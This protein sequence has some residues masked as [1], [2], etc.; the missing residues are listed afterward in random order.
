MSYRIPLFA[1]NM[2]R[3][4]EEAVVR[5]LRS[6]WISMGPECEALEAEFAAATGTRYGVAV[7]N[8]T[9]ALHMALLAKGCGVGDEVIVPSLT[10]AATA[11]AVRYTG[12]EPVFADIVSDDE[13]LV[14]RQTIE[15]VVSPR[16]KGIIVMHYA[17]FPVAFDEIEAFAKANGLFLVEDACHAPLSE[18]KGR[19][20]GSLGDVGC[21]SFFSNKNISSGEG[22]MLT[23]DD[24]AIAKEFGL[25]RSHGM[26]VSSYRRSEGHATSYNIEEVGYNYRLDDIRASIARVQ[27]EKLPADLERRARVRDWYLSALGDVE[28][29]T[30]PFR[31]R[32]AF[33]SNYIMPVALR[34]GG[35]RQRDL[36]REAMH[37][38]GVQTSNHYPPV[39]RFSTYGRDDRELPRTASFSDREITLPMYGSLT[40]AQVGEVVEALAAAITETQP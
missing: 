6:R 38:R 28:A 37:R 18:Y 30:V 13:P 5:T 7:A 34:K 10:F 19:K 1:L 15:R 9:V 21:F 2:D 25:L 33:S 31:D 12:A 36:V 26:T 32:R 8:C 16:T 29:V 35:A 23:T 24:A 39:H 40:E 11:N 22:G 20:A 17:G 4:E 14:S 27:L 3:A